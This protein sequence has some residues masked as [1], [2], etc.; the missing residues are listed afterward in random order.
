MQRRFVQLMGSENSAAPTF[1]TFHSVFYRMIRQ[2]HSYD[3]G[4]VLGEGE[5]RM[6][7]RSFLVQLGYDL[8]DEF[9]SSV[10]GEMSLVKN[11]L[12]E[13][14]HYHSASIGA[15]DFWRLLDMYDSYKSEKN[16]IDFDDMLTLAYAMLKDEPGQLA[17]WRQTF[18]FIM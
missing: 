7:V 12:H 18:P 8:E 4:Q 5:R 9:L 17:R 6:A 13:L 15:A 16:K 11:E 14:E 3:L 2:R 1:G 10:L